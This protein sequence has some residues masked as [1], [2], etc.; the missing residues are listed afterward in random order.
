MIG[1]GTLSTRLRASRPS[2]NVLRY[3]RD[4]GLEVENRS[5]AL[6]PDED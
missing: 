2:F 5:L 1:A 3:G 4:T 6:T